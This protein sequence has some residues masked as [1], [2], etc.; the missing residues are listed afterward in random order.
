MKENYYDILG[1]SKSATPDELKQAYR[2]LALQYHP[3]RNKDNPKVAEEK[4]KKINQAYE[5]LSDP[6]RKQQYDVTGSDDPNAFGGFGAGANG[7]FDFGA[8]AGFNFDDI[9]KDMFGG[10]GGGHQRSNKGSDIEET[11]SLSFEEAYTGKKATLKV[12]KNI[13]CEKCYGTGSKSGK[14]Q[15]C[16]SCHGAGVVRSSLMG[17]FVSQTCERCRG[18]GTMIK[19]PCD[20][21]NSQGTEK[22]MTDITVDIPAGVENN[23]K[24]RFSGYGN[25]GKNGKSNGDLILH[26][27][28]A[29]SKNFTRKDNNLHTTLD[30]SLKDII[31]GNKLPLILPGNKKIEVEIPVGYSPHKELKVSGLGFQQINSRNIGALIIELNLVLPKKFTEEQKA[32][33]D[34]FDSSLEKKTFTFTDEQ[35]ALLE[36]FNNAFT[37]SLERKTP[38]FTPEQQALFNVFTNSLVKKPTKFTEEQQ[39]LF[40]N[41]VNSLEKKSSWW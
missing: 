17:M 29:N 34:T 18:Q 37:S 4:F 39:A 30:I 33:F 7:G 8:G 24:L 12:K 13:T 22:K 38:N 6:Q 10:F 27:Y 26:C 28:V 3:D 5:T 20:K 35:R 36:A 11:I 15:T 31:Y 23:M 9:F 21:C 25:S 1:V 32:L 16:G 41:F 40:D 2:K 19:D 14:P